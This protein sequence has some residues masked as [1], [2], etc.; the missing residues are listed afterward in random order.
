MDADS[1][2]GFSPITIVR[3]FKGDKKQTAEYCLKEFA[4]FIEGMQR[5]DCDAVS[6]S[7][8]RSGALFL[9]EDDEFARIL[10]NHWSK[11]KTYRTLPPDAS[12]L[13]Y[14]IEAAPDFVSGFF[15]ALIEYMEAYKGKIC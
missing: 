8:I 7:E 9:C 5:W 15:N 11:A 3:M 10:R 13:D 2:F 4:D 12:H 14:A 1:D 6:Y